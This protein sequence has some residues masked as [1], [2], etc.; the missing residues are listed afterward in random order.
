MR[1]EEVRLEAMTNLEIWNPFFIVPLWG[2]DFAPDEEVL[3]ESGYSGTASVGW[4]IQR[5][6][7]GDDSKADPDDDAGRSDAQL[8]GTG[9][10]DQ[11]DSADA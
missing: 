9:D 11:E 7:G 10:W 1:V 3:A 2:H 8:L 6:E 4:Q 5:N